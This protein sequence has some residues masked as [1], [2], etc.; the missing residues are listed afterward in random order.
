MKVII[1]LSKEFL[2]HLDK[3]NFSADRLPLELF[4]DFVSENEVI[5][6]KIEER[7]RRGK[8]PLRAKSYYFHLDGRREET[9]ARVLDYD[10]EKKKFLV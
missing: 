1:D 10:A 9:D 3:S 8:S 7:K 4:D 2:T 6:K 5:R